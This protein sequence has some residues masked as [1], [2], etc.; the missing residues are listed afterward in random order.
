GKKCASE[1]NRGFT[2]DDV[3]ASGGRTALQQV[4]MLELMLGQIANYCP[5]ISRNTI[6]KN[7]TSLSCIWQTIRLHYGFQSTG[8]HFLDFADI[9]LQ[10]DERPEDLY[11]RLVAFVEDNMLQRGSVILHHGDAINVDEEMTP[12]LENMVVLTWLRLINVALPK[13]VKQRYGTELR[14]RTLASIKPEISKAL[15]SLLDEIT[16]ADDA[17]IMRTDVIK[18]EKQLILVLRECVTSYTASCL[19]DDECRDTL[20]DSLV[21]LCIGLRPL[22]GPPAVI[23][24]DPAPGFAA[25]VKDALL[26]TYRLTI[27]LGR[28]KNVNK[29][30]VA[31]K[32]VRE[33]EH[34]L[35]HQ[36]PTGGAVTQLVL[37]IA[38]ANLNTRIRNRGFS[39]RE[40]WTQRDQFTNEQLPLTD[41]D[42]IRQQHSL[43]NANH[44][45]SQL[46]KSPSHTVSKALNIDVG[47]IVYLYCDRNKSRSR[48]RYL[49]VSV[50]GVWLN[51]SKFIGNQLRATSYRVK[52][53]EC[54]KVAAHTLDP[55]T[56]YQYGDSTNMPTY[57]PT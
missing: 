40:L 31:E 4:Y 55:P 11:Q 12:S 17:K 23:R 26:S 28:V 7:S 53:T 6:V 20:R 13:L 33:L 1:P 16:S 47:D 52:R 8:A 39:A 15:D 48:C 22:D 18:S 27:E 19:I 42:L 50:D 57:D 38:T 25:L 41:Y 34:E 36:Q 29:N 45:P 9:Q 10:A 32:A 35:L 3:I 14:A 37:S 43:R 46:S 56:A 49:V 5:V 2:D 44:A 51:V 30:P 24:T 54:C 21:K